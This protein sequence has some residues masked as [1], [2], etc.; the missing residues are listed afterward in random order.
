[1]SRPA[2]RTFEDQVL[3]CASYCSKQQSSWR[4][5]QCRQVSLGV[6]VAA[7]PRDVI[8]VAVAACGVA[9]KQSGGKL[10]AHIVAYLAIT[11][12]RQAGHRSI[13]AACRHYARKTQLAPWPPSESARHD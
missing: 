1:V 7:V 11:L 13:A 8:D 5:L 3:A 12:I 2:G 9:D 10:P 6:L 4:H